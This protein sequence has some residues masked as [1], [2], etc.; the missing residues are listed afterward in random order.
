MKSLLRITTVLALFVTLSACGGETNT[1]DKKTS[2]A[3]AKSESELTS[4]QL[5][6]GIGPVVEPI[7]LGEL[8]M[9]WVEK[10]R[11]IFEMKCEMCH[12]MDNRVVGP[13]LGDVLEKR[14]PTYVMNMI[15]NPGEMTKKH[16]EAKKLL[17]EY[18]SIMPF[19]NV[20]RE[21][22]RAIVEFL[23]TQSDS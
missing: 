8:N 4:F 9:E 21:D 23:R 13:A 6:H 19:Q 12:S 2:T 22:A 1:P 5:E 15:L 3:T 20:E 16:P 10:G 17:Q 18:M 14:T 11:A 7:T